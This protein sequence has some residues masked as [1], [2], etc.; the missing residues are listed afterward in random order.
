MVR[1]CLIHKWIFPG[2]GQCVKSGVE[3]VEKVDN[4]HGPFARGMFATE[5]IEAH[6]ATEEDCHIVISLSRHGTLVSQLIGDRW[7]EDR[8]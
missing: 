2:V 4:L 5:S 1:T 8:V 3:V 6:N 7:R